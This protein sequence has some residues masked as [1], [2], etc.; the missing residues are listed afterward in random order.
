MGFAA[1]SLSIL[2]AFWKPKCETKGEQ[3]G[4]PGISG[5]EGKENP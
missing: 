5:E 3:K 1:R 4:K 2:E